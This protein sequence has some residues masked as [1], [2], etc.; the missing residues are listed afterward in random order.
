[1]FIIHVVNQTPFSI[2]VFVKVI[3]SRS[4]EYL[5][6]FKINDSYNKADWSFTYLNPPVH[7]RDLFVIRSDF[8]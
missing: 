2:V 4:S 7:L 8:P 6:E 3:K 1:M 5:V